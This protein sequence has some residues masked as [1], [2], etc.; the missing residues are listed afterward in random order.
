[1]AAVILNTAAAFATKVHLRD[2]RNDS[3]CDLEEARASG[4]Y[5]LT[6]LMCMAP[7]SMAREF[8]GSAAALLD[9]QI[10]AWTLILMVEESRYSHMS[11]NEIA[12]TAS[13]LVRLYVAHW[14]H[15]DSEKIIASLA[16]LHHKL[17]ELAF[18][19][20]LTSF[21]QGTLIGATISGAVKHALTIKALDERRTLIVNSIANLVWA[22]TSFLGVVPSVAAPVMAGVAGVISV[23]DVLGATI[24][25]FTYHIRDYRDL[26]D[27]C[28]GKLQLTALD[29]INKY[30]RNLLE[31]SGT[32][33]RKDKKTIKKMHHEVI[34]VITA[35]S[36]AVKASRI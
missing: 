29:L 25:N 1:M 26:I 4:L 34:D 32:L 7:E 23:V 19:E 6:R 16:A 18:N 14:G 15:Y 8:K 24:W 36:A 30:E 28:D 31:Q 2:H 5:P 20:N 13:Q 11:L 9:T 27:A 3:A 33:S 35:L 17:Q 10:V 12:Q 22:G 21:E